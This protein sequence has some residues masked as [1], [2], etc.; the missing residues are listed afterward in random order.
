M[1]PLLA[2][3][4]MLMACSD[5]DNP[6]PQT[7]NSIG[8]G[9]V[10]NP[11]VQW[12]T[13]QQPTFIG[14]L[15]QE[16]E[17]LISVLNDR[18]PNRAAIGDAEIA[19][20][21]PEEAAAL[22]TQIDDF[23]DRGG[24]LVMMRPT[25]SNFGL[26]SD[27]VRD[28][29]FTDN[30][31]VD[32][33]FFA[34]NKYEQH[35]TMIDEPE[36]DG[37]YQAVESSEDQMNE[38]VEY[39]KANPLL[40]YEMPVYDYDNETE[41][42]T[43]Y[44]NI[45]FTPFIN[46]IDEMAG[47]RL[48]AQSGATTRAA[49]IPDYKTL[50][51][52]INSEGQV[53]ETNFPFSMNN[54]ITSGVSEEWSLN[55]SSVISVRYTVYPVYMF[56]C[57][58]DNAGDYYI[59]TGKVTPHNDVMW[60]PMEKAGGLFNMGRCRIYGY[61]FKDMDVAF[62]LLDGNQMAE[63]LRYQQTPIPENENSTVDYTNGFSSSISGSL[64]GGY[65][66]AKKG[67]LTASLGFQVGWESKTSYSLKTVA[68]TRDSSSPTVKYNYYTNNVKLT[69]NG[70]DNL[71]ENFP[72]AC[73]TEFDAN[74]VWVWHVPI[75]H[76]GVQDNSSKNFTVRVKV[77]AA[78]SSWYHWRGAV[79]YDS[80]RK[81]YS[82]NEFSYSMN[83]KPLNRQPWGIIALKN[84]A[85]DYTVR[86][87]KVYADGQEQATIPSTYEYNE[88]GTVTMK[89]GTYSLTFEYCDPNQGNKVIGQGTITGIKVKAG[90]TPSEATTEV[91]TAEAV[92][93]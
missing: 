26:L 44:W 28:G 64:S 13:C 59:V 77:R 18:F 76:A 79:S 19:F 74:S 80:N 34:F 42:N 51:V 20:V 40:S 84:A 33:L 81:D 71:A 27:T 5:N 50:K 36:F 85:K 10:L 8:D 70:I 39:G 14:T 29:D 86:N 54:V 61:W 25:V 1:L 57:N 73:R 88:R 92:I 91:S 67:M 65:R 6:E 11:N 17:D 37:V 93:K 32:E 23:Y 58:G 53:F 72:A 35:Y 56:S 75:G 60:G 49:D 7:A 12:V 47:L 78:Y 82:T 43:N 46:W 31:D 9:F 69:D 3:V 90:K 63:G 30:Q 66:G 87:I 38:S 22:G 4:S 21:T 48:A 55:K 83:L 68:Y 24:L 52:N 45:R 89:E 2:A 62:D 41:Y 16:D 15:G